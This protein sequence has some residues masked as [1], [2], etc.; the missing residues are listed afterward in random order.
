[1]IAG[2]SLSACGSDDGADGGADEPQESATTSAAPDAEDESESEDASPEPEESEESAKPA[3]PVATKALRAFQCAPGDDG[4]WTATGTVHNA[5]EKSVDYQVTVFVG[6]GNAGEGRMAEV[7]NVGPDA[8][9][10]FAIGNLPAAGDN[11][12]CNVKIVESP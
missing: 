6:V 4:S 5:G 10:N 3:E 8:V 1:M 2:L 9:K 7:K 12:V 11:A